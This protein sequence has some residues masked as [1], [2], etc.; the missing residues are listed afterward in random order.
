MPKDYGRREYVKVMAAKD[1]AIRE[2]VEQGYAFVT[3]AFRRDAAPRGIRATEVDVVQS[4][5]QKE[6]Y[7]TAVAFAYDEVGNHLPTMVSIWQR[8]GAE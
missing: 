3:N 6:G 4:R 8:R 2:L 5:L 1:P 7:R